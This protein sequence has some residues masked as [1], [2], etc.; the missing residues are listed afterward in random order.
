M[1]RRLSPLRPHGSRDTTRQIE[2]SVWSEL[3]VDNELPQALG[4]VGNGTRSEP[5]A[6]VQLILLYHLLMASRSNGADS[7]A[8]KAG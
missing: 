4:V 8:V 2:E 3:G 5:L 7:S 1:C 6:V